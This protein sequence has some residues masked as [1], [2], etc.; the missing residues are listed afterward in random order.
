MSFLKKTFKNLLFVASISAIVLYNLRC[1]NFVDI[2]KNS[3]KEMAI[4]LIISSTLIFIVFHFLQKL[5]NKLIP[6]K[7]I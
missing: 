6:D 1:F 7:N 3:G 2:S 4:R 5:L